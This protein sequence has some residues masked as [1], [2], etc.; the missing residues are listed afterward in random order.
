MIIKSSKI[1]HARDKDYDST[2]ARM[3]GNIAAGLVS[4]VPVYTD[5][6]KDGYM[7]SA[8]YADDVATTSIL[9][10]NHILTKARVLHPYEQEKR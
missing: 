10:A 9:I 6:C 2:L 3:A 7:F 1:R 5:G 4:R 8:R